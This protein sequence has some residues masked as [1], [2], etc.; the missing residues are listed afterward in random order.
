MRPVNLGLVRMVQV[1][2][3]IEPGQLI[4]ELSLMRRVAGVPAYQPLVF[5]ESLVGT[6]VYL[7]VCKL[8]LPAWYD[9][10]GSGVFRHRVYSDML[11]FVGCQPACSW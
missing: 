6:I 5:P 11:A 1:E 2:F 7:L 9:I 8:W 3:D 10:I 4:W